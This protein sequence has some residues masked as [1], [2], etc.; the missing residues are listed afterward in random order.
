M[1]GVAIDDQKNFV[2][3]MGICFLHHAFDFF[4]FFHQVKLGGQT[5]RC[6]HQD[7]VT[8][9]RFA[10]RYRIKTDRGRIAT[11]LANN[12][13]G[14]ALGPDRQLFTRCSS[15]GVCRCKQD[16]GALLCHVVRQFADGG[17][18][19]CAVDTS[20]H[21]DHGFLIA[22]LQLFLQRH[23]QVGDG[24]GKQS[25]DGHGFRGLAGFDACF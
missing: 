12:F 3:R 11:F 23:Q 13:H 6:V 1:A 15:E 4:K 9:S 2:R 7:H 21:D 8:S 24:V 25:F 22:N 18:F 20:Y 5:T 19:A 10:G 17:C 16:A 14:I